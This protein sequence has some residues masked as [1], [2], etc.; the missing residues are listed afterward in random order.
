[1]LNGIFLILISCLFGIV[2]ILLG[3]IL[4]QS[5][6]GVEGLNVDIEIQISNYMYGFEDKE[7]VNCLSIFNLIKLSFS[8][9]GLECSK[10]M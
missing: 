2:L 1:M 5:L 6:I 7:A 3:E 10:Q 9:N 8:G 4:L